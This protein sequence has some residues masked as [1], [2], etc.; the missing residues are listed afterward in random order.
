MSGHPATLKRK[1]N[2][3]K[4]KNL[5]RVCFKLLNSLYKRLLIFRKAE[6]SDNRLKKQGL[7]E[8]NLINSVTLCNLQTDF[9]FT[10]CNKTIG[11]MPVY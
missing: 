2:N 8:T 1:Y 5:D 6:T 10:D 3:I 9:M 7:K 4:Y 11:I